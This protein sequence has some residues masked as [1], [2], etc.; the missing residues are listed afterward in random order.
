MSIIISELQSQILKIEFKITKLYY[1]L[2]TVGKKLLKCI[3][4]Y[5]SVF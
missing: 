3:K 4:T 5:I 1:F 2:I